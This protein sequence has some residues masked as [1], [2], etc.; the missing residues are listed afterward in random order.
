MEVG[1]IYMVMFLSGSRMQELW[2]HEGFH[3]GSRKNPHWT[4][5]ISLQRTPEWGVRG[6]LRVTL[7]W[8][9]T[10]QDSDDARKPGPA[11]EESFRH[12][13]RGHMHPSE[14]E[15]LVSPLHLAESRP[16]H[17]SCPSDSPLY[18]ARPGRELRAETSSGKR[19]QRKW[20]W[21]G[22]GRS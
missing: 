16:R 13:E 18:Q 14:N 2:S 10:S 21:A 17:G 20:L 7:T 5:D 12:Q 6:A 8:Q 1:I 11:T 15:S 3:Q 9:W 4:R 22:C 19:E